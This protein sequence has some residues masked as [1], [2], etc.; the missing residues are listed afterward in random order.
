MTTNY[1]TR[2]S[3]QPRPKSRQ[4]DPCAPRACPACGGLE[5]LCRPRF[6]AG[7]L[8]TEEDLNRLDHYIVGKNRLHNRYLHGAGVVCGLEVRCHPCRD[9]VG[10]TAGYA[11]S[12]CGDDIVV[13]D[14]VVAPVCELIAAC[15]E[16]E[17]KEL[18]CEP[19]SYRR[20]TEEA[21]RERRLK[22]GQLEEYILTIRYEERP[23]RG[24][25]PLRGGASTGGCACGGKSGAGGCGCGSSRGSCGCGGNGK[26][27]A[28][29]HTTQTATR[30]SQHCEPSVVC[31]GYRF[32]VCRAPQ[33]DR[34]SLATFWFELIAL[35]SRGTP[36]QEQLHSI[37]VQLRRY[38][39]QGNQLA[40]CLAN[41]FG[42]LPLEP[43][44]N[45]PLDYHTWCVR[46]GVAL[47]DYLAAEPSGACNTVLAD[48]LDCRP[49][50]DLDNSPAYIDT[51]REHV[52]QHVLR[53]A[54]IH[55]FCSALMPAC[56]GDV[57][58]ARL[59]LAKIVV[60]ADQSGNCVVERV[61]NLDVRDY[62]L[63]APLVRHY[64][65]L[66][67]IDD[68]IRS[69]VE[70]ICCTPPRRTFQSI[71]REPIVTPAPAQPAPIRSTVEPAAHVAEGSRP[72]TSVLESLLTALAGSMRLEDV[73]T[74]DLRDALGRAL[75]GGRLA[76]I[77]RETE[78]EQLRR[79]VDEQRA[80]LD[81][82]RRRLDELA[83]GTS[84]EEGHH[85]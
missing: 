18:D 80:G 48:A 78:L 10:V 46:A 61:C 41:L 12:P 70:R 36:S 45:N 37:H 47:R 54:V 7:Q 11:I 49:P 56:S 76:G 72:P 67:G 71:D 19:Y 65:R 1:S 21:A 79:T 6:F 28:H 40:A 51:V 33:A 50:G 2:A 38:A 35:L 59:P 63:T 62:V 20:A 22:Q 84:D 23:S 68:V 85:E 34:S 27:T 75:T 5:C 81:A 26:H 77:T 3:K 53:I 55:C 8:L 73:L 57:D 52:Y 25:T 83:G 74:V 4:V 42:S 31:E 60:G 58:D 66:T 9:R 43:A 64:L 24:V 44:S 15:E 14:D 69:G 30:A 29:S 32:E 17:R 13:C 82:L 39:E 16:R